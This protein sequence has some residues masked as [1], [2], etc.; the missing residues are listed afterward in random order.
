M[1]GIMYA[2]VKNMKD[3]IIGKDVKII[4][5]PKFENIPNDIMDIFIS[6]VLDEILNALITDELK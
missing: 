5:D 3:T 2:E 1:Y 4:G 6:S